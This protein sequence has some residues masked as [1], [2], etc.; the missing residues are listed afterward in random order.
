MKRLPSRLIPAASALA[1]VLAFVLA[2]GPAAGDAHASD[3]PEPSRLQQRIGTMERAIDHL[4]LDSPNFL[5]TRGR[6][7]HGVYLPDYGVV[8]TFNAGLN[9]GD[10][11]FAISDDDD[12]RVVIRRGHRWTHHRD[13]G[14]WR[15]MDSRRHRRGDDEADGAVAMY[16]DGKKEL[17]EALLDHAGTL[18]S[19]PPGQW[20]AVSGSIKDETLRDERKISR[21]VMRVRVDDLKAY[22]DHR[23]SD[24]E[25]RARIQVEES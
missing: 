3:P 18:A 9:T 24:D 17:A 13:R 8:F 14:V 5:V 19:L 15:W 23:L 22:A 11:F 7:A 25:L 1:L 16:E 10:S 21:L 2:L 6:N 12:S 4:L 20:L